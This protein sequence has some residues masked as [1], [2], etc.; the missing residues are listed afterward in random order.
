MGVVTKK[1]RKCD[2]FANPLKLVTTCAQKQIEILRFSSP[3]QGDGPL[4]HLLRMKILRYFRRLRKLSDYVRFKRVDITPLTLTLTLLQYSV[5][6]CTICE[7]F[8]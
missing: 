5:T 8:L 2:L 1:R 4:C 6:S 7:S 3:T